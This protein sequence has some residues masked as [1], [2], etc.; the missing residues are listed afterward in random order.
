MP[1]AEVEMGLRELRQE[2]V[3]SVRELAERAG[4]ATQTI[5]DLE[6]GAHLRAPHPKTIRKLAAALGIDPGK[7]A[8]QLDR[9]G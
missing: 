7:L 1:V 2:R 6:H 3:L 5:L 4:M 9:R 8:E